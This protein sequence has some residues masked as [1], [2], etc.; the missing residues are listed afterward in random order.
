MTVSQ[1]ENLCFAF[2]SMNEA[3]VDCHLP[4]HIGYGK[5]ED[6]CLPQAGF[7]FYYDRNYG[8]LMF[9]D[10]LLQLCERKF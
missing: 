4:M 10:I 1:C 8:K 3:E 6:S 5:N 2:N 7:R 9:D